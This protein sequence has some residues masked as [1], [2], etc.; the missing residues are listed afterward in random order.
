MY[1]LW[2]GGGDFHYGVVKKSYGIQI[3]FFTFGQFGQLPKKSKIKFL[4]FDYIKC[5]HIDKKS[6]KLFNVHKWGEQYEEFSFVG[7]YEILR[8]K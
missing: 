2:E 8:K 4:K 5:I 1:Y 6:Y 7:N 3:V